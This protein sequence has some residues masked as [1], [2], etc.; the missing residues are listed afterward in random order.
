MA[1]CPKLA[2]KKISE[3][4]GLNHLFIGT[5]SCHND[6]QPLEIYN[7]SSSEDDYQ[8]HN[9]NSK[10]FVEV[11]GDSG[12][13]MHVWPSNRVGNGMRKAMMAN[14]VSCDINDGQD[15]RIIDELGTTI[16]LRN[17]HSINGVT[18]RIISL[19]ALRKDGWKLVDDGN[20]NF[21]RLVKDDCCITFV[22]KEDNLHY[23]KALDVSD[24]ANLSNLSIGTLTSMD[25]NEFHDLHGFPVRHSTNRHTFQI[26]YQVLDCLPMRS[27]RARHE[28]R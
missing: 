28:S 1:D 16:Q 13:A 12:A 11:L 2:K 24:Y 8:I 14:G 15:V 18:K 20:P 9:V 19:N 23:L 3:E 17:A 7:V 5:I 4:T 25:V 26:T 21:T 22:E 10:N 27:C 6:C